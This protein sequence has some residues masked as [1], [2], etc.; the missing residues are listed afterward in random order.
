MRCCKWNDPN[1]YQRPKGKAGKCWDELV[2]AGF[3]VLGP[4]L[5]WGGL[6]GL[7]AEPCCGEMPKIT[8]SY[9][10]APSTWEHFGI[11]PEVVK[12]LDKYGYYAEWVNAGVL[13]VVEG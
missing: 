9:Y 4:E 5:G 7:S 12:I 13:C 2:E 1:K 3:A 8:A 11:N 10:E 6:F